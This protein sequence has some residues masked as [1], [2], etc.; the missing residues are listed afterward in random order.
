MST[1][2]C[3]FVLNSFFFSLTILQFIS[4]INF[5][6]LSS[7]VKTKTTMLTLV[8]V[9]PLQL[10]KV[11]SIFAYFVLRF[12][13]L[14]HND[15]VQPPKINYFTFSCKNVLPAGTAWWW[16]LN[17]LVMIA[18]I[19]EW[20]SIFKYIN[21]TRWALILSGAWILIDWRYQCQD[22]KC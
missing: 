11:E 3:A 22:L 10:Q 16:N 13:L 2:F 8:I 18:F 7:F 15:K 12:V 14:Y 21:G 17:T 4:T 19:E 6:P 5:Y 20:F 1:I 9:E